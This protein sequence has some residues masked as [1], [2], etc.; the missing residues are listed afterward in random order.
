MVARSRWWLLGL[1]LSLGTASQALGQPSDRFGGSGFDPT[2]GIVTTQREI[3]VGGRAVTYTARAGHIPIRDN[4]TGEAH[5]M[6]F[7][8]YYSLDEAPDEGRPLTFVWNGGPGSSSSLVHLLGFGPRRLDASG[9]VHAN[10]ETWLA[11]TDLVF[12]DPIGTGYSRPTKQEYGAEFY[13]DRGDAESVGEFIRVFLTRADAWDVPLFLAG[14]SFGVLRATRVAHVLQRRRI[15][16]AGLMHIGLVPPLAAVPNE[17]AIALNVPTYTAA[18]FYH[19][20]LTPNLQADFAEAQQDSKRWALGTYAP[21]MVAGASVEDVR[22]D[23]VLADLAR[24]TGVDPTGVDSTLVLSMGTF[25]E[26]LLRSEGRVVGHYDSRLTG[27][28][29]TT[30]TMYDPTT[31]P[32]LKDIIDEVG[33]V[34]YMREELGFHS[35]LSYQGPFGG[36]YPRPDAFRG[37]WMSVLWDRS[38]QAR[39]PVDDTST[40][41]TPAVERVL[42]ADPDLLVYVACGYYDLV[43]PYAVIDHMVETMDPALAARITVRTYHGGHAVYTDDEARREMKRDVEA[44]VL[45]RTGQRP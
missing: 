5:G 38:E 12:V 44:F 27:P 32:S 40:D 29:D 15:D 25:A 8:V 18:A 13:Q 42:R 37:D 14:E 33:V 19:R 36:G 17:T 7:F 4:A 39:S 43:C 31:D 20:R 6:M 41:S 11:F 9:G 16:V 10:D 24:M 2:D 30:A 23:E 45:S 28:L 22:R 26:R 3:T 21:A 1:A 34:R 35:D